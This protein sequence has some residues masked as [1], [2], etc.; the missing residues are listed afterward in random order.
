MRR[1]V[2]GRVVRLGRNR[3]QSVLRLGLR[4]VPM[5]EDL[6]TTD[7]YSSEP[8]SAV[9]FILL[10]LVLGGGLVFYFFGNRTHA[11]TTQTDTMQ[12]DHSRTTG[13]GSR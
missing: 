6:N 1:F 2:C 7:K 5:D 9:P 4:E 8:T 3:Q 11:P 13:A 12:T 10:A